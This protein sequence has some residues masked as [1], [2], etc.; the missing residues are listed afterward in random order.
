MNP[1]FSMF[2]LHACNKEALTLKR[3]AYYTLL[4]SMLLARNSNIGKYGFMQIR[5]RKKKVLQNLTRF[6]RST[7]W[8]CVAIP[9]I[10]HWYSLLGSLPMWKS[11]VATDASYT[12]GAP[13]Q[14]SDPNEDPLC[15]HYIQPQSC[16]LCSTIYL[17]YSV[18][19]MQGSQQMK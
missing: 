4:T 3:T 2:E 10:L 18:V 8:Q 1:Y 16:Y 13:D 9:F 19:C 5:G 15:S 12:N 14:V 11:L 6:S 17:L 7:Q